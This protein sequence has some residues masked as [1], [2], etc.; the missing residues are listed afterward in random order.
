MLGNGSIWLMLRSRSILIQKRSAVTW[1]VTILI[2]IELKS[3]FSLN[4]NQ[5]YSIAH[6]ASVPKRAADGLTDSL[7]KR[8]SPSPTL[9]FSLSTSSHRQQQGLGVLWISFTYMVLKHKHLSV[10]KGL[11]FSVSVNSLQHLLRMCHYWNQL[12]EVMVMV[13]MM[14][15]AQPWLSVGFGGSKSASQ[16][17][18][19]STAGPR[20]STLQSLLC[21]PALLSLKGRWK[22]F[23]STSAKLS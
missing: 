11:N 8:R 17:M 13:M 2:Q 20:W 19:R 12:W 18:C 9:S 1:D 21:C 6:C 10:V 3:Q 16:S 7:Y 22:T 4:F 15:Q 14:N 5:S 23:S